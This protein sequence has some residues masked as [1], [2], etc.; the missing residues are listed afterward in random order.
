MFEALEPKR[1]KFSNNLVLFG[2][3]GEDS[4]IDLTPIPLIKDG[5]KKKRKGSGL[6]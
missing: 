4:P 3:F 6:F 5:E 1:I 2:N